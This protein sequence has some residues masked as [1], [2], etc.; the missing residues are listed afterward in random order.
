MFGNSLGIPLQLREG[1][2]P[3][4]H[5]LQMANYSSTGD[6]SVA[7]IEHLKR[8][9]G[10]S[11]TLDIAKAVGKPRK[12]INNTIYGLQRRGVLNRTQQSPPLWELA[13]DMRGSLST[14]SRFRGGATRMGRGRGRG[15]GG[16]QSSTGPTVSYKFHRL[17]GRGQ[18]G[19]GGLSTR[20]YSSTFTGTVLKYC[21]KIFNKL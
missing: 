12:E 9:G 5:F 8:V 4:A 21:K 3:K 18:S 13:Q 1:K 7:V 19:D 10:S 17:S 15:R 20:S 16:G 11:S 2:S 14:M 6:V